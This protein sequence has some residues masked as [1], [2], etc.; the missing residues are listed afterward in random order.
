MPGCLPEHRGATPSNETPR[1]R[2]GPFAW[3]RRHKPARAERSRDTRWMARNILCMLLGHR[4]N[5]PIIPGRSMK[6]T[7][8]RCHTTDVIEQLPGPPVAASAAAWFDARPGVSVRQGLEREVPRVYMN[9]SI[10]QPR[11][12]ARTSYIAATSTDSKAPRLARN[13]QTN[14]II[15]TDRFPAQTTGNRQP[16]RLDSD[17]QQ[18]AVTMRT[19]ATV[20]PAPGATWVVLPASARL[21]LAASAP[22]G[23]AP[24]PSAAT[25]AAPTRSVCAGDGPA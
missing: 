18:L 5:R 24:A 11:T 19:S 21:Q 16:V 9:T 6:V 10:D 1:R 7:C 20:S 13:G 15:A 25:R 2:Q 22:P 17:V 8:L 4:W 3:W 23:W 12:V 14:Q